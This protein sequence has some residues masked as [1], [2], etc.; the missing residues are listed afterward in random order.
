MIIDCSAMVMIEAGWLGTEDILENES[1]TA[2]INYI[3]INNKE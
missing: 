1:Y 3:K 2:A